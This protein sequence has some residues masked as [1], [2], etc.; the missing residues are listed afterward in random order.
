MK[1][2]P[3]LINEVFPQSQKASDGLPDKISGNQGPRFDASVG[4]RVAVHDV[5]YDVKKKKTMVHYNHSIG[6]KAQ[7]YTDPIETFLKKF[8]N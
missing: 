8:K 4:G 6:G 5:F 7:N 2:F 3:D 1:N